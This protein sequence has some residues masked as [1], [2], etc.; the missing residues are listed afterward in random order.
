MRPRSNRESMDRVE[1]ADNYTGLE[2][3]NLESEG[4]RR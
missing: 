1:T 3:V 2:E 4:L